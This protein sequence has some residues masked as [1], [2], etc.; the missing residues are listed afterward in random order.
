MEKIKKDAGPQFTPQS[1]SQL[2]AEELKS[3]L[4][5]KKSTYDLCRKNH[6]AL[7]KKIEGLT[8]IENKIQN[9]FT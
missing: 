8:E 9:G 2:S 7:S 1:L 5:Q 3:L 4:E 6:G